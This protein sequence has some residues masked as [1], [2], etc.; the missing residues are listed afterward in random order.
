MDEPI[1]QVLKCKFLRTRPYIPFL[2]PISLINS[3]HRGHQNITSNIKLPLIVQEWHQISLDNVWS[4][5]SIWPLTATFDHLGDLFNSIEDLNAI[6]L[7]WVLAWLY[8]PQVFLFFLLGGFRLGGLFFL[9][10]VLLS[11]IIGLSKALPFL[12]AKFLNMKS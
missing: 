5:F 10:H 12:V 7:V 1:L 8:D 11:I 2:I 3:L 4:L 6:A 9:F